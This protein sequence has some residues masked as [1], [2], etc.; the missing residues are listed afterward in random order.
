MHRILLR[1]FVIDVP[2]EV[3]EQERG[4]WTSALAASRRPAKIY[5]EYHV[6]ENGAT[7][8]AVAVQDIG[9][10]PARVHFDIESDDVDAEVARL[11]GLGAE[12]VERHDDWIVLR[13]PAGLPFCVTRGEGDDFEAAAK[14]VE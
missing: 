7:P 12:V 4:F 6:L 5:P 1:S 14:Q 11:V 9:T 13:D 3:T 2:S 10:S 8:N